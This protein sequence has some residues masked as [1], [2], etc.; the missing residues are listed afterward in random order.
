MNQD[1][2]RDRLIT[3]AL[4]LAAAERGG[5]DSRGRDEEMA[6]AQDEFEAA[7][8]NYVTVRG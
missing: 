3:A 7:V 6:N 8:D 1:Q 5:L 4:R 2:A